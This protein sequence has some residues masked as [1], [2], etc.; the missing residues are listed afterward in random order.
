M[1]LELNKSS[2]KD[3][4]QN[5]PGSITKSY[6]RDA[7]QEC[8]SQTLELFDKIKL[9][10]F[11]SQVHPDFSP[12]GWHLGHIAFTES[13]WLLERSAGK[14]CIFP[15]YRKLY[16][17]DGLP[18][19]QRVKLP[20]IEETRYYLDVVREKVFDYLEVADIAAVEKIWFFLLQHECQHCETISIIWELI[21]TQSSNPIK[22]SRQDISTS[23]PISPICQEM[24]KIPAGEFLMG[25]NEIDAL[26]NEKSSYQVYLDTYFI[27]RYPV[28]CGNFRDFIQAEGYKNS[29]YWSDTGWTWLQS[30]Q[31]KQPLY[32]HDDTAWDNHPVCG[33]S[34]YEAEAYGKFVG[35]RLPTEAEWEKAARWDVK[36]NRDRK[37]PWG[38][39]KPTAE[40][41]NCA[42]NIYKPQTTPVN[43][44]PQGQSA[45]GM[46]DALGNVW[47]WTSSWFDGYPGFE[48]Y[49]YI[50]YSQVYFDGEHRVLKGG[51]WGTRIWAMRSSFRNWYHPHVREIFAG[52]RCV[53]D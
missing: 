18:K 2:L 33:V 19:S 51:S 25:S 34:Y 26:D 4:K 17:A 53:R 20:S 9:E 24:I 27:D 43:A 21:K 47:E 23:L 38:E 31:L 7:F 44:Y 52:F 40:Y 13:L 1:R 10:A 49:P 5:Y 45:S 50:G 29:Q 14:K 39:E 15:E 28:T 46:Y 32:W 11:Y 8:R 48:Y 12:I 35:K 3:L 6:I 41:C 30:K 37:Y 42:G 22:I 16:A 36:S